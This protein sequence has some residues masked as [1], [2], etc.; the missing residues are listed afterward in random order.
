MAGI[1][2][3]P[4]RLTKEILLKDHPIRV[5]TVL[6]QTYLEAGAEFTFEQLYTHDIIEITLVQSGAGVHQILGQSIPCREGDIYIINANV[7]HAYAVNEPGESMTLRR[8]Y[9]DPKDWFEGE[10]AAPGEPRYCFG[11]F[12]ESAI[13]AYA[14]PSALSR[15]E[16]ERLFG[17][18]T[19][20]L[21][22][23]RHEWQ[24][25]LYIV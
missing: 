24:N 15:Q 21:A 22:Q 5:E 1:A 7:P 3:K 6:C 23:R 11:I 25:Q 17:A 4:N 2:A 20:E 12:S 8:L 13:T 10:T 14:M 18:I 9:F 19:L 16:I